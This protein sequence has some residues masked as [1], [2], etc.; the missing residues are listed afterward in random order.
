[1]DGQ[2]EREKTNGIEGQNEALTR[3]WCFEHQCTNTENSLMNVKRSDHSS[4]TLR[5]P[6]QPEY[7]VVKAEKILH[8][9]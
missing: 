7:K 4:G 6:H 5:S 1:M 8:I 9:N 2:R 3:E